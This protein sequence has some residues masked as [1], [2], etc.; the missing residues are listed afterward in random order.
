MALTEYT[1]D[2]PVGSTIDSVVRRRTP[3]RI[4]ASRY[5]D[6]AWAGLMDETAQHA[7]MSASAAAPQPLARPTISSLFGLVVPMAASDMTLSRGWRSRSRPRSPEP[8]ST[9]SKH[10]RPGGRSAA[11][12]R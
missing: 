11:C 7:Q 1:D 8:R 2:A 10:R 4:P 9:V 12:R 5:T 6:P 3:V